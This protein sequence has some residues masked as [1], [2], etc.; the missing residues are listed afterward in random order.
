MRR[1][2][3][4]NDAMRSDMMITNDKDLQLIVLSVENL[5]NVKFFFYE[6]YDHHDRHQDLLIFH[7]ITTTTL[8]LRP[9]FRWIDEHYSLGKCDLISEH[10]S[11]GKG[12]PF[13]EHYSLG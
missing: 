4:G 9:R 2:A 8:R 6:H 3:L 13:R 5:S 1:A 12:D 7:I 10:Y 11:L